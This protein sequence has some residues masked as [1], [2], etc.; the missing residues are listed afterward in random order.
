MHLFLDVRMASGKRQSG[1]IV[2]QLARVSTISCRGTSAKQRWH[3]ERS[4]E[5]VDFSAADCGD[6]I[7]YSGAEGAFQAAALAGLMDFLA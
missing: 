1:A 3:S 4:P 6:V 2:L 7:G 5:L